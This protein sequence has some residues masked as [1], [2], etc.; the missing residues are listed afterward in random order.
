MLADRFFELAIFDRLQRV[1]G[2]LIAR[3]LLARRFD[4]RRP[5]LPTWSAR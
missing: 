2:G 4:R 3:A 1:G 5:R